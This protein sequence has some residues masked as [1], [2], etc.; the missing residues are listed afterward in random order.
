[1]ATGHEKLAEALS[2]L[3]KLQDRGRRVMRSSSLKREHRERL[4]AAGFLTSIVKGW[5]L[6]RRPD[7]APGDTTAWY[8]S[9]KDFVRGYCDQRFGDAWYVAPELSITLHAGSTVLPPQ[10]IVYARKGTNGRLDL[11]QETSLF[12]YQAKDFAPRSAI[13]ETAGLRVLALPWALARVSEAYYRSNPQDAQIALA[14]FRDASGLLAVLLEG[15]HSVVAGRLAG[16]LRAIGRAD[17]SDQIRDTMRAAGFIVNE[18]DPFAVARPKLVLSRAESPH[19]IRLQLSWQDMRDAAIGAFDPEPGL[20]K[21][22]AAY[23]DDV[24]EQYVSDAYHSLSIEGYQVSEALIERVRSGRWN[25]NAHRGDAEARNAMAARGYWLAHNAVKKSIRQI[26]AGKNAGEI[27]RAD[28]AVWY[29]ELFAP[30]VAAGILKPADLAGYRD[31]QVYIRNSMHVPPATEAVRDC[32]PALFD[33]L[34]QEPSAAVRAVLGH[35]AFV[36]MHPYMDGNG[37]LGRFLM[38]AMLASGGYPW[39]IIQTRDRPQ[40]MDALERASVSGDISRLAVLIGR[41]VREQTMVK[42]AASASNGR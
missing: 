25:P 23:L 26:L 13:V 19:V 12:D 18:T 6:P 36:F 29:R 40:Y 21:R 8:A 2:A 3:K 30:S 39:T 14:Q 10:I 34:V 27:L 24:E 4:L 7:E 37:R 33:L 31:G 1:M 35:W 38:N 5:Y 28:H 17:L 16:A 42:A 32:M 11:P 22:A 15:G 20:P 41:L 9:M